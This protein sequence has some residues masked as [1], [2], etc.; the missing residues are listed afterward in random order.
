[1]RFMAREVSAVAGFWTVAICTAAPLPAVGST[2]MT[3]DPL[4]VLFWTGAMIVGWRAVQP[5]GTTRQWLATGLLM[6]LGFLSKYTAV[7][8][9][10]CFALFFLLWKPS[11]AH[12]P[13][14]GT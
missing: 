4:L 5:T 3:V 10:V 9:I 13:K 6:G 12:L 14:P 11:R 8:Q 7:I 1:L 2:L